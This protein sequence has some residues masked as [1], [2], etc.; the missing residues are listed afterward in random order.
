MDLK[1]KVIISGGV[2]QN[3]L[4]NQDVPVHVEIIDIDKDYEDYEKLEEYREL[5]CSDAAFIDCSFAVAN[6]ED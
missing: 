1:I 2:V 5:I 4:K 6:F 3:V